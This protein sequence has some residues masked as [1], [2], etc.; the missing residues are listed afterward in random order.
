MVDGLLVTTA[1]PRKGTTVRRYLVCQP[2]E[3]NLLGTCS[4]D[5]PRRAD[6]DAPGIEQG[7]QHQ[8]GIIRRCVFSAVGHAKPSQIDARRSPIGNG[9]DDLPPP[10]GRWISAA[11][12]VDSGTLVES[13]AHAVDLCKPWEEKS[14]VN[15]D[16][17]IK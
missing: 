5:A 15:I 16:K 9:Q 13:E 11:G 10:T 2:A 1:K 7:G 4:G 12:V 8:L 3:R 17:T 14:Y 6:A